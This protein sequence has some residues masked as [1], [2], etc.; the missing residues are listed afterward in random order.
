MKLQANFKELTEGKRLKCEDSGDPEE[1]NKGR[2]RDDKGSTSD[3][4][5][6]KPDVLE[7]SMPQLTIKNW[8]KCWDNYRHTSGWGQ[9]DNHRTQLAYLRMCLSEEIRTA[10]DYDNLET[11]D[12][13]LF[14]IRAYMMSSVMPLTLQRLDLFRYSPPPGQSQSATTQTV[15]ELFH[16][17][18]G[19]LITPEEVLII[20]LLNTIQEKSVLVKVQEAIDSKTTWETVRNLIVKIDSTSRISDEFKQRNIRASGA[21][22]GVKACRA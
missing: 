17:C 16:N 22:A 6:L 19:F 13:A 12:K 21:T 8:F 18:E 5:G 2:P 11:V 3:A 7:T 14:E 9:G 1:R 20:C 15:V 10:V 4:K